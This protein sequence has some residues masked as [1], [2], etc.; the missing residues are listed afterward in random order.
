MSDYLDNLWLKE[1]LDEQVQLYNSKAFI[2]TDPISIPHQFSKKEDIEIIGFLIATLSWG[3][4][5]IILQSGQ[6]LI[7]LM[8]GQP[9]DF[10]LHHKS[11]DLNKI[12]S[13]VHRTFNAT[14]LKFFLKSLQR[15]YTVNGGLEA[16]FR[17]DYNPESINYKSAIIGFRTLFLNDNFPSRTAK[18]V[19]NP[20]QN[21]ACKRLHMFLRWMVRK[22][23]GGVDFGMWDFPMSKLSCPLDLHSGR[24]ARSLGLLKRQQNDWKAVEELD[25]ILRQ[26]DPADPVKYDFALF[27]TS[28]NP[29]LVKP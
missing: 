8:E 17:K 14:D 24:V 7:Q 1:Y 4:R 19:S 20:E 11:T 3:N 16:V 27:G 10:I 18:H 9:Y 25:Q 6:K 28:A 12:N 15:I 21:S 22:D 23:K 5:K 2:E 13:F 26:F 29:E